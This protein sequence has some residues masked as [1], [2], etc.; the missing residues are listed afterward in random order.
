MIFVLTWENETSSI[1]HSHKLGKC[2]AKSEYENS[3]LVLKT[4]SVNLNVFNPEASTEISQSHSEKIV[5]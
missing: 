3:M 2:L 1:R 5:L 4:L